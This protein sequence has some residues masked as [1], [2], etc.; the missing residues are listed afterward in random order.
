[1]IILALVILN[2]PLYIGLGWVMFHDWS[3]FREALKYWLTPD[4]ISLFR[5]KALEDAWQELKLLIFFVVCALCV[6]GENQLVHRL[7]LQ[8]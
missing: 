3:G 5:G 7:F 1:M 2:I 4:I 6:L 8:E